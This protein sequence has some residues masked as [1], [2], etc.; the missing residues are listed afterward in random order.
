MTAPIWAQTQAYGYWDKLPRPDWWPPDVQW[1][2][3]EP[4]GGKLPPQPAGWDPAVNGSWVDTLIRVD[5]ARREAEMVASMDGETATPSITSP[6]TPPEPAPV[7]PAAAPAQEQA[8]SQPAAAAAPSAPA[9]PQ[10]GP[11]VPVPQSIAGEKIYQ[12]DLGRFGGRVVDWSAT[13][14]GTPPKQQTFTI[15][16]GLDETGE[17]NKVAVT[18]VR[19]G[20]NGEGPWV[21]SAY[22]ETLEDSA[23]QEKYLKAQQAEL[24]R[25]QGQVA[26][27]Q[28]QGVELDNAKKHSEMLQR[29]KNRLLRP[30]L[31]E[32]TDEEVA[33]QDST[34]RGLATGETN[35]ATA[36]ANANLAHIQA[37]AQILY[38]RGYTWN[39]AMQ[40]ATDIAKK[41]ADLDQSNTNLVVNAANAIYGNDVTQR[42]QDVTLANNRLNAAN[43][44]FSDDVKAATTLNDTLQPGSTKG[45]D[46]LV[47]MMGIRYLTAKKWGGL[48]QIERVKPPSTITQLGGD[49][50]DGKPL[51][52]IKLPGMPSPAQLADQAEAMLQRG[53]VTGWPETSDIK[54][55][56]RIQQ[57]SQAATT[58]P[59][60]SAA[61]PTRS[62][63]SP[64][65]PQTTVPPGPAVTTRPQPASVQSQ[66]P[67]DGGVPPVSVGEPQTTRSLSPE[68]QEQ[69][70][71]D[72]GSAPVSGPRPTSD[73]SRTKPMIR[74]T[75]PDTG[76]ETW[77]DPA[78]P[79]SVDL[80]NELNRRQQ[81]Y[82]GLPNNWSIE[83]VPEGSHVG[84]LL[85]ATE[86]DQ[87]VTV[88]VAQPAPQQEQS[89]GKPM[90]VVNLG[91]EAVFYDPEKN[92]NLQGM[93]TVIMPAETPDR[94][95]VRSDGTTGIGG[96]HKTDEGRTEVDV[97]AP[98]TPG[99]RVL[100][101]GDD[102]TQGIDPQ[103]GALWTGR[104]DEAPV[105][106]V[107]EP[108]PQQQP[109][110]ATQLVAV[111]PVAGGRAQLEA[112]QEDERQRRRRRNIFEQ[113]EPS[114]YVQDF[115]S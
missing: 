97:N 11:K 80:V 7:Q 107:T 62:S 66:A 89:G 27:G 76:E 35:A 34:N 112:M 31:G 5:Q 99:S 10:R 83:Q 81:Q 37:V 96:V 103:T 44:G 67:G 100:A 93:P 55:P 3:P 105:G 63:T 12:N 40:M 98:Q 19:S 4:V 28:L 43:S 26:S 58:R 73:Q 114:P 15:V 24:A 84:P 46:A 14:D 57:Q 86:A 48:D 108:A 23:A 115:Y 82:G 113:Y 25:I 75:N 111:D 21:A 69:A 102:I 51:T 38:Q 2:P 52:P 71:G 18:Y 110:Q 42:G 39:Q 16:Y 33:R 56:F 101:P 53:G 20:A 45:A 87:P 74:Y 109:Q 94:Y 49:G 77:W 95:I 91:D 9:A 72:G 54:P 13:P 32:L 79:D 65:P 30:E 36:Q 8:P 41:Q 90:V 59:S 92:P 1:P 64:T 85:P 61:A 106:L 6:G 68:I 104:R 88:P 70:P 29:R 22:N 78:D 47:G 17:K 60:P 50:P